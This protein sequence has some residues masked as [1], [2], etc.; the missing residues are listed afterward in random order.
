MLLVPTREECEE[1]STT[2]LMGVSTDG[3]V[4][5]HMGQSLSAAQTSTDP[6]A[7]VLSLLDG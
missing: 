6:V 1:L 3:C 4:P 7:S 2:V 5:E